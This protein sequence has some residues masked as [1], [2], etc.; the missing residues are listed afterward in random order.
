[1]SKT[2]TNVSHP[3]PTSRR[4][5]TVPSIRSAKGQHKQ[6][7]VTAYDATFAR[8]FEEAG[9][10][11]LLVGDSLGMVIQ[12]GSNTLAVTME[13]MAYHAKAVARGV[14]HAHVVVDMPFLA[15]NLSPEEALR[16][17]GRLIAAGAHAVKI[18][19]GEPLVPAI[20]RIVASGIPVMGHLG[21]TPQS[22]HAMGG[23]RVQGR[24]A[25][26]AERLLADA[27]AL[28][29]AGVYAM[30]IEG[31]PAELAAL[32]TRSVD[33]PTFGIGAGAE[34]DGQVLVGYDL[35][36]LTPGSTPKFVKRFDE[37]FS[38]GV[39]A[40]RR[41]AEEVRSSSFPAAEHTYTST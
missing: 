24:T 6:V 37:F 13:E 18:E 14:T 5:I 12:G 41:Y 19:G 34:C 28:E 4:A 38:R 11:I 17:A 26:E 27:R 3:S 36:G 7:M 40:A 32:V 33:V 15:A 10:E 25:A 8:L 20:G 29:A 31:I 39:R 2:K 35:L 9:I 16:N 23:F 22:V 1:M 21:L 30:V